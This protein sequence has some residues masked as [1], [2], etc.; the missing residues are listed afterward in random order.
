VAPSGKKVEIWVQYEKGG[1]TFRNRLE[2][3]L[4]WRDGMNSGKR[5]GVPLTAWLYT[6]S[7][8]FEGSFA[9]KEEGNLFALVI[10]NEALVNIP[11]PQNRDDQ[12]WFSR[13]ELMPPRGTP[14]A[15][16]VKFLP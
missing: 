16:E 12:T 9:A 10:S 1:K 6:G 13:G 15:L 14:V 3:C 5:R 2:S 4:E 7:Y 8:V 11:L